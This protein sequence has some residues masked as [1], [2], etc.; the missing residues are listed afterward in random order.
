MLESLRAELE[1]GSPGLLALALALFC[2]I[3]RQPA[4]SALA[5]IGP[6]RF[7]FFA[8]YRHFFDGACVAIQRQAYGRGTGGVF[9][10]HS[11]FR[12]RLQFASPGSPRM[13]AP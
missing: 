2:S 11:R 5:Q 6:P 8:S 4:C 12:A 13:K 1:A 9:S 10:P 7:G 3:P